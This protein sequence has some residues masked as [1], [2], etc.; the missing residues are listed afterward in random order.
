VLI[1]IGMCD[2]C[3]RSRVVCQSRGGVC[4]SVNVSELIPGQ[5][6]AKTDN[7]LYTGNLF[8]HRTDHNAIE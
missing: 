3:H 8:G 7:E 2:L 1:V 5:M 6:I 4:Q